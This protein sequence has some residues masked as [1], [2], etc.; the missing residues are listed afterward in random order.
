M[1][2]LDHPFI[3]KLVKSYKD[4]Y[5]VYFLQEFINGI[6]LFDCLHKM[7]LLDDQSTKFYTASLVLAIEY[8][9]ERNIAYRDLKP[10]NVIVDS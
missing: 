1:A 4:D 8:M 6:D 3:T 7:G 2:Y 9:H 10:E 5:R